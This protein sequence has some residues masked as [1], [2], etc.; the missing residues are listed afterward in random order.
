MKYRLLILWLSCK[1]AFRVNLGDQ[2]WYRGRRYVVC[3]GV[4]LSSWDLEDLQSGERLSVARCECHKVWTRSNMWSSVAFGY[5]F[6]MRNW[7]E[8]WKRHGIEPWMRG[9][10]I[11]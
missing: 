1:W 3:N 4:M 6:Y 10:N 9:C 7:F 2:V 5:R 11:W 8:I